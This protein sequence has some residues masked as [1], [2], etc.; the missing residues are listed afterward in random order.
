MKEV[1]ENFK[2]VKS[3]AR[4]NGVSRA[5]LIRRMEGKTRYKK[6][7]VPILSIEFEKRLKNWIFGCL[8][9]GF[10]MTKN[11]CVFWDTRRK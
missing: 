7:S 10:C 8:K 9:K 1:E 11:Q 3:A 2:S 4:D 5:T 6:G